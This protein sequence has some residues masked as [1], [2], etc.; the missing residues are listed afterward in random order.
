MKNFLLVVLCSCFVSSV[1][2][3]AGALPTDRNGVAVQLFSPNGAQSQLLTVVNT[4]I[5]MSADTAWELYAP[6]ACKVRF[7]PTTARGTNPTMTVL[8]GTTVT[9][10]VNRLTPFINFSGCTNGELRRQ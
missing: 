8:V 1:A 5:N 6:T 9:K 7:L 4:T 2:M 3:A 10:G